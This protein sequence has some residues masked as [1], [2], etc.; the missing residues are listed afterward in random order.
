[1]IESEG[2]PQNPMAQ[3]HMHVRMQVMQACKGVYVDQ[4]RMTRAAN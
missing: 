3:W 1:M 4:G 2:N